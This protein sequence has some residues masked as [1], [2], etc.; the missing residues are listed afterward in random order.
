MEHIFSGTSSNLGFSSAS[1]SHLDGTR[2]TG[3]TLLC[4][5]FSRNDQTSFCFLNNLVLQYPVWT[6]SYSQKYTEI[7]KRDRSCSSLLF[8][9]SSVSPDW[10]SKPQNN[11]PLVCLLLPL[12]DIGT[13]SAHHCFIYGRH[14]TSDS[15]TGPRISHPTKKIKDFCYQ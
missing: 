7:W 5:P 12:A 10:C 13:A 2:N 8:F 15:H 11:S 1:P 6:F 3:Q 4:L 14:T 9:F